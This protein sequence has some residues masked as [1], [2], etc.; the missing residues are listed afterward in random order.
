MCLKIRKSLEGAVV[1]KVNDCL[2]LD[3]SLSS[4]SL[5]QHVALHIHN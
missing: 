3:M 1:G 4:H 2:E 5:R